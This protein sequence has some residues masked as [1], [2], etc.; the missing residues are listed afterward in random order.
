VTS[1]WA[2]R[3]TKIARRVKY[4]RTRTVPS[5]MTRRTAMSWLE[6]LFFL[7]AFVVAVA[8]ITF[9]VYDGNGYPTVD[10]AQVV[11]ASG[12]PER[13]MP[14]AR[15]NAPSRT[16]VVALPGNAAPVR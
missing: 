1:C 2:H 11:A 5:P 4:L 16:I 13:E 14:A 12:N 7:V 3:D 6:D 9:A 15:K 8:L 10:S